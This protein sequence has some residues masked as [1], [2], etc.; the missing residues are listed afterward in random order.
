M[1]AGW[2]NLVLGHVLLDFQR[3]GLFAWAN[4]HWLAAPWEPRLCGLCV[5]GVRDNVVKVSP[6]GSLKGA[7]DAFVPCSVFP[8]SAPLCTFLAIWNAGLLALLKR[9]SLWEYVFISTLYP[10]RQL[11]KQ[12]WGGDMSNGIQF[13]QVTLIQEPWSCW[14]RVGAA[15]SLVL[16]AK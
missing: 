10:V 1:N 4:V 8:T 5:L 6:R 7:V 16:E 14:M 13:S 9:A 12:V 3:R 15:V 2:S 11:D